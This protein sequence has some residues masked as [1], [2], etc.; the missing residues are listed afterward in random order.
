MPLHHHRI[1]G[2]N[3][4]DDRQEPRAG[5]CENVSNKEVPGSVTLSN[6]VSFKG[7]VDS[8]YLLMTWAALAEVIVL[9]WRKSGILQAV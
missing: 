9:Q 2:G 1:L 7:T 5:T 3:T 6:E 8:L 4:V